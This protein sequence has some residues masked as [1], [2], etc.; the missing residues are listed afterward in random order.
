M[1]QLARTAPKEPKWEADPLSLAGAKLIRPVVVLD[2]RGYF[3]ETYQRSRF[4]AAGI[5]ADFIQ[6]NQSG[7]I[8]TGT[9]RGLHFQIPPLAQTKL[10]RVL[11]GRIL[12]V[13]VDLRRSSEIPT[14]PPQ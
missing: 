8:S 1:N 2:A 10:I 4:A 14:I 11:R 6:D 9:V 5:L 3:M 12:D 7:S 13:I